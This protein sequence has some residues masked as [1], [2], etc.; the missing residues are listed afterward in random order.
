MSVGRCGIYENRPQFCRDYPTV[1]DHILPGC[2][3]NFV[4]DERHGECQPELCQENNCCD[5]PREG[6]EPEGKS[7]DAHVGGL[8]CKHLRWVDEETT[9]TAE[10]EASSITSEIYEDLMPSIRGDHV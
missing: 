10:N 6:G 1:T 7:M 8:P 2:T 4:G 9:K 5:Y 3:Y